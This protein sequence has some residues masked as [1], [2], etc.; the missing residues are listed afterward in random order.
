[1]AKGRQCFLEDV[2]VRQARQHT[3]C[4]LLVS[5]QEASEMSARV[6]KQRVGALFRVPRPALLAKFLHVP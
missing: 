5:L 4:E 3:R 2:H 1:M 6:K